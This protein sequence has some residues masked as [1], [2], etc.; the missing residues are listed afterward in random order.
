M[1]LSFHIKQSVM[2]IP[3]RNLLTRMQSY[4]KA[5]DAERKFI[6]AVNGAKFK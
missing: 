3:I 5:I 1:N 6:V 4:S 2:D